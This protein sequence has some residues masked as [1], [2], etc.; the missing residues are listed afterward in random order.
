MI[1]YCIKLFHEH[2]ISLVTTETIAT[3][4][5]K[6]KEQSR[7]RHEK[8]KTVYLQLKQHINEWI[9]RQNEMDHK[10]Y[11]YSIFLFLLYVNI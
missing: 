6:K 5:R 2:Y 1:K 11:E 4:I 9:M 3:E 10:S 8:K 7:R